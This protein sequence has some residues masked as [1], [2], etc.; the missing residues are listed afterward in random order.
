MQESGAALTALQLLDDVVLAEDAVHASGD[1]GVMALGVRKNTAA[2]LAADGDYQPFIFDA[3]GKLWVTGG[4][5]GTQYA[6]DA[7][8]A[9]G[10]LGTGA[11]GVRKDAAASLA[12]TD[13]DYTL[14]I[15]DST[16]RHWVNTELPDAAALADNVA[17]PTTPMTG[18]AGMLWNAEDSTW[19]RDPTPQEGTLLASAARTATTASA[20]QAN[21]GHRGVAV[22]LNI[23]SN[24]SAVGLQVFIQ[25]YDPVSGLWVNL[26][27]TP[28]A[29]TGLA[30]TGH[31]LYPGATTAPTA[32]GGYVFHSTGGALPRHWRINVVHSSGSSV[33]YSCG[34]SLMR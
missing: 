31:V 7:V 22:W 18:S 12:G 23:T 16:G 19:E 5:G 8:H 15:Y 33:T 29:L 13:G 30:I 1:K 25:G 27:P 11:L 6:E 10:D 4:S 24:G 17:N 34:Y 2:A 32:S 26:A 14:P 28:T 3:D 20:S 9:T 21:R